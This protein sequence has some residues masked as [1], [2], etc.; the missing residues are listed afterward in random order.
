[1]E[2]RPDALKS[3]SSII[4]RAVAALLVMV[5]AAAL[6]YL[7]GYLAGRGLGIAYD[8]WPLFTNLIFCIGVPALAVGYLLLLPL[9]KYYIFRRRVAMAIVSMAVMAVVC[10]AGQLVFWKVAGFS[11]F[12]RGFADELE[13][14]ASPAALRAWTTQVVAVHEQDIVKARSEGRGA[15]ELASEELPA[16]LL[17]TWRK[18]PQLVR[19]RPGS[20]PEELYV[21]ICWVGPWTT[22]G[23][24]VSPPGA[25]IVPPD[26]SVEWK[27]GVYIYFNA[28]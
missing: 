3:G 24:F 27:S 23:L 21:D 18:R 7:S 10:M 19:V 11:A 9:W 20:K 1:M 4:V 22:H 26:G 15:F 5:V 6:N 2:A 12:S 14:R 16:F 28:K 17:K 8:T 13:L 25:E